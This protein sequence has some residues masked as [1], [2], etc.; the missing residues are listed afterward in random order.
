MLKTRIIKFI[1][2][3]NLIFDYTTLSSPQ[4]VLGGQIKVTFNGNTITINID[5]TFIK[6]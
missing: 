3:I 4:K 1:K 5:K 6:I 2:K